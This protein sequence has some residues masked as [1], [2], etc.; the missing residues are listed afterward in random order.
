MKSKSISLLAIALTAALGLP[1]VSA[2]DVRDGSNSSNL[3][4]D[5]I[6]A[7]HTATAPLNDQEFL[8]RALESGEKE[9]QAAALA[10]Q[11]SSNTGILNLAKEIERDHRALNDRLRSAGA[12]RSA[13]AVSS[14]VSNDGT[15]GDNSNDGAAHS[16]NTSG[17]VDANDTGSGSA[18]SAKRATAAQANVAAS[19]LARDPHMAPLLDKRGEDFDRAYVDMLVTMHADSIAAF[20]AASQGQQHSAEVRKIA[21]QALPTLRRHAGLISS[22]QEAVARN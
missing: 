6:H 10:Q 15:I 12:D 7:R 22:E 20:E 8:N 18:G 9:V 1:T 13:F 19:V 14:A 11:R 4:N 5:E 21:E 16:S 2:Q 3:K 17:S